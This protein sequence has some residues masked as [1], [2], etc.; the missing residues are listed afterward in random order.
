M[1]LSASYLLH[2][3]KSE[4]KVLSKCA[5]SLLKS[6][7]FI[8]GRDRYRINN[9]RLFMGGGLHGVGGSGTGQDGAVR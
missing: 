5:L 7:L 1:S 9:L 3:H 4:N 2:F 6:I 8:L